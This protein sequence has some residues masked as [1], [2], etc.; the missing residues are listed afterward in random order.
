MCGQVSTRSVLFRF[1]LKLSLYRAALRPLRLAA[2]SLRALGQRPRIGSTPK[3]RALKARFMPGP[4][5]FTRDWRAP[6]ALVYMAIGSPGAMLQAQFKKRFRRQTH[7]KCSR[8][9][10]NFVTFV[11]VLTFA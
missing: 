9:L 8:F 4:V 10:F 7:D 2:Y 6:S 1:S 3:P 5:R 11:T